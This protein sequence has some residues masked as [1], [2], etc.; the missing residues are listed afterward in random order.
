MYLKI[1][2]VQIISRNSKFS[3]LK[4]LYSRVNIIIAINIYQLL[5]NFYSLVS[6]ILI[7]PHMLFA[8][9]LS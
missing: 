5:Y 4:H 9:D 8:S 1:A 6:Q 7:Y 3:Q 2:I